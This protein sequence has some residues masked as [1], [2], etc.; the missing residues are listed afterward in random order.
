MPSD[1]MPDA[2]PRGKLEGKQ[3][4]ELQAKIETA[5]NFLSMGLFIEQIAQGT[6]LTLKT[7]QQLA[8]EMQPVVTTD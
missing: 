3:Q 1:D 2:M 4:G 6:G 8:Q 5:R 7:I